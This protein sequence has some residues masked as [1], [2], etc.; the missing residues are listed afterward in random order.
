LVDKIP[1]AEKS[2]KYIQIGENTPQSNTPKRQEAYG[3]SSLRQSPISR[4]LSE[5]SF[6]PSDDSVEKNPGKPFLRS[7]S[8]SSLISEGSLKHS[9]VPPQGRLSSLIARNNPLGRPP[10]AKLQGMLARSRQLAQEQRSDET[11]PIQPNKCSSSTSTGNIKFGEIPQSMNVKKVQASDIH[12]NRDVTSR[13]EFLGLAYQDLTVPEGIEV[14]ALFMTFAFAGQGD[15]STLG[16]QVKIFHKKFPGAQTPVLIGVPN[17]SVTGRNPQT[18]GAELKSKMEATLK[19]ISPKPTIQALEGYYYQKEARTMKEKMVFGGPVDRS[20]V[21]PTMRV[22]AFDADSNPTTLGKGAAGPHESMRLGFGPD[23]I[24]IFGA[25]KSQERMPAGEIL[26]ADLPGMGHGVKAQDYSFAYVQRQSFALQ[27]ARIAAL[28]A[29]KDKASVNIVMKTKN[30]ELS[31][32]KPEIRHDDLKRL[33]SSIDGNFSSVTLT[34][35]DETITATREYAP[36]EGGRILNIKDPFPL[37]PGKFN[38]L[39]INSNGPIGTSGISSYSK[40]VQLADSGH[41]TVLTDYG[42]LP[43]MH[44]TLLDSAK[45]AGFEIATQYLEANKALFDF[46]SHFDEAITQVDRNKTWDALNTIGDKIAVLEQ[47]PQLQ[48]EVSSLCERVVKDANPVLEGH[49]VRSL[50]FNAN[51][52][53]DNRIDVSDLKELEDKLWSAVTGGDVQPEEAIAQIRNAAAQY[54]GQPAVPSNL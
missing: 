15:V 53:N 37:V 14:K 10:D 54:L 49:Y 25:E 42:A 48:H 32:S 50:V 46:Q 36:K 44:F 26:G 17:R 6:E 39:M 2:F 47:N 16:E 52:A 31:K 29:P 40:A 7:A 8:S 28:S 12:L 41:T 33:L 35:G 27:F 38:D 21:K 19:D 22:F 1:G 24:G 9:E 23:C 4:F 51:D 43:D 5:D 3:D 34:R 30:F 18:Y 13:G 45:S 20:E 11:T